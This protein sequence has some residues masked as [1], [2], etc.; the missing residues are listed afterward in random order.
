M[1]N[2][3]TSVN[4]FKTAISYILVFGKERC[5]PAQENDKSVCL[6]SLSKFTSLKRCCPAQESESKIR[7]MAELFSTLNASATSLCVFP[8][9]NVTLL[10]LTVDDFA[11]ML[12]RKTK[13][14]NKVHT[15]L[16]SLLLE[17][18]ILSEVE[19]GM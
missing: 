9:Q 1:I 6:I 8:R 13:S 19:E 7:E 2:I 17:Q 14:K 18:S 3:K 10:L 12:M 16:H 5:Y 11:Q 4:Q 15:R